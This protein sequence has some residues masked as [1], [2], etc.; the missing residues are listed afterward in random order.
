MDQE[1]TYFHGGALN[2]LRDRAERAASVPLDGPEGWSKSHVDPMNVLRVFKT[3][4]M[5]PGRELRAYQFRA[6]GNGNGVVWAMNA[7]SAF[8]EPSQCQ[9]LSEDFL[10][11]PRPDGAL[12]HFMDAITGDGSSRCFARPRCLCAKRLRSARSGTASPGAARRS[13][14]TTVGKGVHA[15]VD[16]GDLAQRNVGLVRRGTQ[17]VAPRGLVGD[18]TSDGHVLHP[19]TCR[20]RNPHTSPRCIQGRVLESADK[21]RGDRPRRDGHHLLRRLT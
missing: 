5:K 10:A 3:L 11:C 9:E 18:R 19:H 4:A 17:R 2:S 14:L 16:R 20:E 8:P 21:E 6:G 15:K 7:E 1:T 12:P 13:S